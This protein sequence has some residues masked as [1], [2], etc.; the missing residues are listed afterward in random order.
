MTKKRAIVAG[1]A[2]DIV[3]LAEAVTEVSSCLFG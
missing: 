2:E 3:R 1:F